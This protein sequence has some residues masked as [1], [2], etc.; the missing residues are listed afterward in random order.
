MKPFVYSIKIFHKTYSRPYITDVFV[1]YISLLPTLAIF[2]YRKYF[3]VGFA[4]CKD[5]WS[6]MCQTLLTGI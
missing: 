1:S 2:K 6:V 4:L 5:Y 3:I